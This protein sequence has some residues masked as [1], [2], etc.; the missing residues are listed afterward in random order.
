MQPNRYS[1]HEI[2]DA[3]LPTPEEIRKAIKQLTK[4]NKATS[5]DN[6]KDKSFDFDLGI[7]VK[8]NS[9]TYQE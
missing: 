9:E 1:Q 4:K 6:I 7:E 8:I 3:Y 5:Y 2:N